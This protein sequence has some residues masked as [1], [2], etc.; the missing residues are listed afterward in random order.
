MFLLFFAGV[1]DDL[2]LALCLGRGGSRVIRVAELFMVGFYLPELAVAA[3][4]MEH[5]LLDDVVDDGKQ[6]HAHD[7]AHEAPQTAEQQDGEQHPEAGKAGGVAQDLGSDDV[8]VQLLQNQ[9]EQHEP[10]R[11]DGALDED[12]QGGGDGTDEGA[13]ERDHVGHTDDHRHQQRTGELEDQTADIAQHADD[14]RVHDL[15]V[16]EAAEHLVCVEDF[17]LDELRP[18]GLD[19]AVEDHLGLFGELFAAGQQVNSDDKADEQV[20]EPR[21]HV[22]DAHTHAAQDALQVLEG[23]QQGGAQRGQI[24]R[25]GIVSVVEVAHQGRIVQKD[26]L[27]VDPPHEA[28]DAGLGRVVEGGD[29]GDDLRHHH[30]HEGVDHQHTE[31]QRRCNGKH[32]GHAV[33]LFGEDAVQKALNGVA[34]RLEQIGDDGTVDEGH[35]DAGHLGD[36][37]AE[38]VEAVDEEEEQDA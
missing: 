23:G 35:Q 26:V 36:R 2:G 3:E 15:A 17:L 14:G 25:D 10:Q 37:V 13:E 9:H 18:V 4:A 33:E 24:A 19:D 12:E 31:Q 1:D 20:L 5:Q 8:A 32:I 22:Y 27:R 16:D 28:G 34:H 29:A 38:P 21:H 11:L 7:H 6:R 30:H